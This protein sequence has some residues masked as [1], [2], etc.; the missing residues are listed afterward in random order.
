MSYSQGIK[1]IGDSGSMYSDIDDAFSDYSGTMT[2][3]I[4][5]IVEADTTWYSTIN[6]G[7]TN[8]Y[9]FLITCKDGGYH[10][11]D[12]NKGILI[13]LSGDVAVQ[14]QVITS[15][16]FIL[17][18]LKFINGRI[19]IRGR[20]SSDSKREVGHIIRNN[21]FNSTD[22]Y[23]EQTYHVSSVNVGQYIYNNI[24][25]EAYLEYDFV[26]S[27]GS[28]EEVDGC[29][30][31]Y[32]NN[33]FHAPMGN[34]FLNFRGGAGGISK[35]F[36]T[37]RNNYGGGA[38]TFNYS[39]SFGCAV[40]PFAYNNASQNNTA[41]S[42]GVTWRTGSADNIVGVTSASVFKSL[43]IS[44]SEYLDLIESG[45][46]ANLGAAPA[47]ADNYRG[48]RGRPRPHTIYG[49]GEKYSIG[50]VEVFGDRGD[51]RHEIA[52]RKIWPVKILLNED[53]EA[54]T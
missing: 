10:G 42:P 41:Q 43:N 30:G 46:L 16:Y 12:Y 4:I 19:I 3:D 35:C 54:G 49:Q 1:T 26:Q 22:M 28:G 47:Y 2:G 21:I 6:L 11:G 51:R 32:E 40:A 39:F 34:Y 8:G 17:E 36:C 14:V 38:G 13:T 9:D 53:S 33:T 37:I 48:I 45:Q 29:Q 25:R 24:F 23:N 52:M 31:L 50:A 18:K 15:S 5:W 7:T 20:N 44:N 27:T